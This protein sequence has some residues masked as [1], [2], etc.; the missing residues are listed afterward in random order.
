MARAAAAEAR[1]GRGEARLRL[2]EAAEA[3]LMQSGYAGLSTR[4]VVDAAGMPLSQIHY[5]FGSKQGLVLALLEHQNAKLL[6][7]QAALFGAPAPLSARWMQACDYLDE[8]L[9]SGYVRVLQEIIAAGY[10]DPELAAAARKALAGWFELLTRLAQEAR[11]T[12]LGPLPLAAADIACLVGV[13]FLGGE[14]MLLINMDLP[15]KRALRGVGEA[16]AALER[17]KADAR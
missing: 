4:A 8:D 2:L 3:C 17:T 13:A 16:I 7:R 14:T 15:V 11:E 6:R 1:A 10:S 5:H 9:E 12:L